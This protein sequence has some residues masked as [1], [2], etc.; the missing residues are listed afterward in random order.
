[1]I[2]GVASGLRSMGA[3]GEPSES[4]R[5]L[6]DVAQVL[7]TIRQFPRTYVLHDIG[8]DDRGLDSTRLSRLAMTLVVHDGGKHDEIASVI[9]RG[10]TT[11][12]SAKTA[13]LEKFEVSGQR[14]HRLSDSR[15]PGWAI[16]EWGA[17]GDVYL[18]A[19]GPESL[20]KVVSAQGTAVVDSWWH[21]G[22]DRLAD[23]QPD[24]TVMLH[25]ERLRRHIGR[26]AGWRLNAILEA[27]QIGSA[28]RLVWG[29]GRRGRAR[30][31]RAWVRHWEDE[32]V[33]ELL[34]P[35]ASAVRVPA[36]ARWYAACGVTADEVVLA[37]RDVYLALHRSST[38]HHLK[39]QWTELETR[40]AVKFEADVLAQL[41]AGVV[42]HD[43]PPHPLRLPVFM[44]L[45]F[46]IDGD[47]D[48]L[49]AALDRLLTDLAGSINAYADRSANP[50]A[51]RLERTPQGW[52]SSRWGLYGPALA[53]QEDAVLIS[54]SLP[55]LERLV[56]PSRQPAEVGDQ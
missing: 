9:Q 46:E 44:T 16:C 20:A 35:S 25:V 43:A 51:F 39:S 6:L 14:F 23:L 12:T 3:L 53:V 22:E 30:I 24:I 55:A 52:W 41:G 28:D 13:R 48:R 29:F 2:A 4:E 27:L 15:L 47:A 42:M 10:L 8:F 45:R 38:R 56:A 18:I 36:E 37:V 5:I 49:R 21:R 31:S 50:L 19:I 33:V 32:R 26:A 1:M 34:V 54:Y 7:P 17:F 40:T 11:W